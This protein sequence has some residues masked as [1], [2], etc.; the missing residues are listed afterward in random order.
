[1]ETAKTYTLRE[2]TADDMFPM[3]RIIKKVGLKDIIST[4]SKEDIIAAVQKGE[5]V[6][7]IGFDSAMKI[8]DILVDNLENIKSDLYGLLASLS[9]LTAQEIG[10]LPIGTFMAM[11]IDV[12]KLVNFKDFFPGASK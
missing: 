12:V 3:V 4:F 11:V 9:G 7:S 5:A 1:M 8:V 2:L 10:K 6:E